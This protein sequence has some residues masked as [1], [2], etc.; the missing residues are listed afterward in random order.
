MRHCKRHDAEGEMKPAGRD[1]EGRIK[2][3]YGWVG[4]EERVGERGH[5]LLELCMM[6]LRRTVR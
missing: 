3:V 4:G 1:D 5:A 2:P 6:S